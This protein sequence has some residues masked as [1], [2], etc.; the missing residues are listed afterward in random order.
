MKILSQKQIQQKIRRLSVEILE[1]NWDAESITLAGINE[2]GYL[3]GEY[4]TQELRR[5]SDKPIYLT[6]LRVYLNNHPATHP[7]QL[8]MPV[9]DLEGKVVVIVDDVT[10]TGRALFYALQPFLTIKPQ[11]LEIAVLVD[12]KHKT[13][14]I[15]PDYVGMS[16]ATTL[17]EHIEI[18]I[19]S[20][21]EMAAFLR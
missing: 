11:K 14:P 13:Y 18:Q 20:D 2:N 9:Q 17:R 6:R 10:N 4:L 8:E 1:R 19:L 3:F 5:R 7:S 16:L 12:R 21:N 15:H